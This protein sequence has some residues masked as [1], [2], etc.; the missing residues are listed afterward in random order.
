M[1]GSAVVIVKPN[2]VVTEWKWV[3][4]RPSTTSTMAATKLANQI[5]GQ[6]KP[7]RFDIPER[8]GAVL[9]QDV[10]VGYRYV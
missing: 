5:L 6:L 8:T 2:R 4:N 10:G 7:K 3:N 1:P 9:H